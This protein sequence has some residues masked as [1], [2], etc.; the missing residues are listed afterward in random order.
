MTAADKAA[1]NAAEALRLFRLKHWGYF[2]V[3]T[4]RC[5]VTGLIVPRIRDDKLEREAG[6]L[7][8]IVQQANKEAVR[9]EYLERLQGE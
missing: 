9:L 6:R 5:P 7:F 4:R 3:Q 2:T 1:D 8:E